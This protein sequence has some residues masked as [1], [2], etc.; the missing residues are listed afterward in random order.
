VVA[1]LALGA[2]ELT[3]GAELVME[4]GTGSG[5]SLAQDVIAATTSAAV[6]TL[7]ASRVRA[8]MG[9]LRSPPCLVMNSN[10]RPAN[11]LARPQSEHRTTHGAFCA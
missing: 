7:P 2:G 11:E 4:L 1:V 8:M 3:L 6:A 9:D 5:P 10:R